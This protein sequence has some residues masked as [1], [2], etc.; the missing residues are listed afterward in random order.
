MREPNWSCQGACREVPDPQYTG[1]ITSLT[2][3]G[4]DPRSPVVRPLTSG[5]GGRLPVEAAG[6]VRQFRKAY[7][8]HWRNATRRW[9]ERSP[10]PRS[11]AD[12]QPSPDR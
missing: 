11:G 1:V 10:A 12:Q 9:A 5:C 3:V 4:S 2:G 8:S 6:V 7:R